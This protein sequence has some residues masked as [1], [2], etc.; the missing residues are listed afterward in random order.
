MTVRRQI[1]T[2]RSLLAA[3][4]LKARAAAVRDSRALVRVLFLASG[5]ESGLLALLRQ[6][7]TIGD[8]AE[9]LRVGRADRLE[10]WLQVGVELGELKERKGHYQVTGTRAGA[11]A[12]E[13]P[14]LVSHYRSVVEYQAPAYGSLLEL[15]AGTK[16]RDDLQVYAQT[17][18]EVS[19]A[20]APF[21]EPIVSS[22]A[23]QHNTGCIL[24]AGCGTARYLCVAL[25]S[26]RGATGVGVDLDADVI[27]AARG[28]ITRA[29]LGNR[30][31]LR[32]A[33]LRSTLEGGR[34]A[35][36]LILLLNNIYYVAADERRTLYHQ[37]RQALRPGGD[38][39]LVTMATPGSIA[40]AQLD[41]LLRVQAGDASLPSA[42]EL[43]ND[44]IVTGF[45]C[46]DRQRIVPGEPFL[47]I[48]ASR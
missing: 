4:H 37:V 9:R 11:L 36:D 15:I 7:R 43:T 27:R 31:E 46:V 16:D 42:D 24:D 19:L 5:V 32:H 25:H 41:L 35:F 18:A 48:R 3:G 1:E 29:N 14:V 22:V 17:I 33:D 30:C 6:P 10:A 8:L 21:I 38:L 2:V 28:R 44:L 34:A 13:D 26:A 23:A 40:S 39:L 12:A 47:A 20:A 45:N